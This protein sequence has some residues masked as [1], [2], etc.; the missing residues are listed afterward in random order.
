MLWKCFIY[1]KHWQEEQEKGNSRA[2]L[3]SALIPCHLLKSFTKQW[4]WHVAI[5]L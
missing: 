5:V 2:A 4:A 1:C 3:K